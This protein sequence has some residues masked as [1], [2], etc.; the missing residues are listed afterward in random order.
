MTLRRRE[1]VLSRSLSICNGYAR[2]KSRH[3]FRDFIDAT[4]QLTLGD[5]G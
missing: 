2:A 1:V 5:N 3:M 4:P